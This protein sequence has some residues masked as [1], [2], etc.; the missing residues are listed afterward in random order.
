MKI[1]LFCLSFLLVFT[2]T[3]C[4]ASNNETASSQDAL[5]TSEVAVIVPEEIEIR[6]FQ[7][8][9]DGGGDSEVT[10]NVE[11]NL[12]D[13]DTSSMTSFPVYEN[14]YPHN[15][16]TDEPLYEV[17]EEHR[18]L[19][20]EQLREYLG[21]VFGEDE[22]VE[23]EI[24]PDE[25]FSTWMVYNDESG[26]KFHSEEGVVSLSTPNFNLE[27]DIVNG[28]FLENTLV[29][30]AL[31][32]LDIENP[33]I[34]DK[35]N[36]YSDGERNLYHYT[37]T[38]ASENYTES[39]Y[40]QQFQLIRLIVVPGANGALLH[41]TNFN[42]PLSEEKPAVTYDIVL[43]YAKEKY[44][45]ASVEDMRVEIYYDAHVEVGYFTPCYKFYIKKGEVETEV[46]Q[47]D[48]TYIVPVYDVMYIKMTE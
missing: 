6:E 44:P 40:N 32:Y 23:F 9:I 30:S 33:Q 20:A 36:Y 11:E 24:V 14:P 43:D 2:L 17:T 38:E 15:Y 41:I 46:L 34:Q 5:E 27:T 48:G 13:E 47:E 21:L 4:T 16:Y 29:K 19:F 7:P 22:A 31:Q 12:I 3:S 1:V 39:V 45:D 10:T 42:P 28:T 18:F 37:I 26:N 8:L 25:L 35:T